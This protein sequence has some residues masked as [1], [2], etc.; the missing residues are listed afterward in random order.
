M[1]LESAA[2][3]L[4]RSWL[5]IIGTSIAAALIA[6]VVATASE[7]LY[8]STAVLALNPIID[9]Q[10]L[11]DPD[12]YVRNQVTLASSPETIARAAQIVGISRQEVSKSITI[13]PNQQVDSFS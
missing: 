7:P 10:Q 4:R 8:R 12:R 13:Q 3:M 6:W 2:N 1:Y 11:R 9:G 5:M